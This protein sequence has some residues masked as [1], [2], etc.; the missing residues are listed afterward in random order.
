[1]A[2]WAAIGRNAVFLSRDDILLSSEI[3]EVCE[4]PVEVSRRTDNIKFDIRPLEAHLLIVCLYIFPPSIDQRLNS[5]GVQRNQ[6]R[7][8]ANHDEHTDRANR[9]NVT[10][11][12][13]ARAFGE[14]RRSVVPPPG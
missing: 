12:A 5:S 14:D 3:Y 1:L 2:C 13:A 11:I 4:V 9:I 7:C 8:L 6:V 10:R